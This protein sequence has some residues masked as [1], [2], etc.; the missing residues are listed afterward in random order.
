MMNSPSQAAEKLISD[1][2]IG[3]MKYHKYE[4]ANSYFLYF[5]EPRKLNTFPA[6]LVL[7]IHLNMVHRKYIKHYYL[8][9]R[10]E[11]PYVAFR[12]VC[13]PLR[14]RIIKDIL[15]CF[16]NTLKA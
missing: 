12:R 8:S 13:E 9:R 3:F 15:D 7:K 6:C 2:P 5:F 14:R 16:D 4:L 11:L 10:I 1:Y